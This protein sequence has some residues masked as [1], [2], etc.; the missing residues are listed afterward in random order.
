MGD[1]VTVPI[2]FDDLSTAEGSH[3]IFRRL[4]DFGDGTPLEEFKTVTEFSHSYD[5]P[6]TKT[7]TLT[8]YTVFGTSTYTQSFNL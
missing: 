3:A 5:S 4:W 1:E 2:M 6:G 7:V 8:V